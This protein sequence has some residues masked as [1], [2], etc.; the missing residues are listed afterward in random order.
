MSFQGFSAS[1]FDA[2]APPRA[3]SNAFNRPRLEAREKAMALGRVMQADATALGVALELRASDEHPSLWNKR[4]VTAQWVFLWRDADARRALEALLDDGRSLQATLSDPTPFF[5]HAFLALH[6]DG[7]GVEV[8]LRVH[9]DAWVDARNLRARCA[10]PEGR[11]ALVA[12]L[13]ALPEDFVLGVTDA[14]RVS[15]RDVTDA[16]L[17]EALAAWSRP[18]QWWSVGWPLSRAVVLDQAGALEEPILAA[19]RALV[20]IYRLV[21]WSRDN[22]LIAVDRALAEAQAERAAHA[23]EAAARDSEWQTRHDAE[24]ARRRDLAAVETRE[25]L[26]AMDRPRPAFTRAANAASDARPAAHPAPAAPPAPRAAPPVARAEAPVAKIT[27]PVVVNPE[28]ALQPGVRVQVKSGP[29]AG[30]VGAIVERDV[31]GAKVSFGLLSARVNLADL[32]ALP[33]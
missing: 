4:S 32:D 30:K 15:V 10:S 21:A 29:F 9:G 16:T 20:P 11:A 3:S 18:S 14:A 28:A 13:R 27:L 5:R 6:V 17:D 26:A 31:R 8:S 7:E 33:T 24:I 2:Y 1:E 12:A 25:R 19:F 23:L 22:D